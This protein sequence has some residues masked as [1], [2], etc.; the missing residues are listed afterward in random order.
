MDIENQLSEEAREARRQYYRD[1]RAKN[2]DRERANRFRY[3]ERRAQKQKNS[4]EGEE[5]GN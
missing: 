1:W 2:R 5:N 4:E 3:W